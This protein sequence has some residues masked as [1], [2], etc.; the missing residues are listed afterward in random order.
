[1]PRQGRPRTS[2]Q[3]VQGWVG[4]EDIATVANWLIED[5]Q[6]VNS[7]SQ[8]VGLAF[9]ALASTIVANGGH[10]IVN[11]EVDAVLDNIGRGTSLRSLTMRTGTQGNNVK[12]K[13]IEAATKIFEYGVKKET[14]Q[15]SD[16]TLADGEGVS[17]ADE[18]EFSASE[19]R[20]QCTPSA[21]QENNTQQREDTQNDESEVRSC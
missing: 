5:G 2:G 7:I 17:E 14:R 1:M 12:Q 13:D 4:L 3:H 9:E 20:S 15:L 19:L 8:L 6:R 18:G 10:A 21:R 16:N 11:D